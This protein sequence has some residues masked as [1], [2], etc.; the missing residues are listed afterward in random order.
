MNLLLR[1][2]WIKWI[3]FYF[4]YSKQQNPNTLTRDIFFTEQKVNLEN[5]PLPLY[6]IYKFKITFQLPYNF[7]YV[8]DTLFRFWFCCF[9]HETMLGFTFPSS[10]L[11]SCS[12]VSNLFLFSNIII[13]WNNFICFKEFTW[14]RSKKGFFHIKLFS[15]LNKEWKEQIFLIVYLKLGKISWSY[16]ELKII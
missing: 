7:L 4:I 10:N 12:S 13:L 8:D 14:K 1:A 5:F 16:I 15:C 9:A 2:L 6:G 11:N 3:S